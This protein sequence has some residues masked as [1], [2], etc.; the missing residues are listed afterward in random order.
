MKSL[1]SIISLTLLAS[2]FGDPKRPIWFINIR[3]EIKKQMWPVEIPRYHPVPVG[4]PDYMV[5]VQRGYWYPLPV[6][7]K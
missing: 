3:G 6:S 2:A 4:H 1:I 5:F 7:Q